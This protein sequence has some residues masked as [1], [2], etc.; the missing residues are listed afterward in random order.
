M[1]DERAW[2]TL[3]RFEQAAAIANVYRKTPSVTADM[4]RQACWLPHEGDCLDEPAPC[5]RC[6]ADR[7]LDFA[8]NGETPEQ[9]RQEYERIKAEVD[10]MVREEEEPPCP[11]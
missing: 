2:D 1:T 5:R 7:Y 8:H 3:D 4:V 11:T 9:H 6:W 10:R